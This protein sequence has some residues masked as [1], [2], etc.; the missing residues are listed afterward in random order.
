MGH[1][2]CRPFRLPVPDYPTLLRFYLPLIEPD[3]RISRIRLSDKVF[4][5]S[6]TREFA[7][8]AQALPNARPGTGI[9]RRIVLSPDPVPCA[10]HT[11]TDAADDA[12]LVLELS[13][14]VRGWIQSAIHGLLARRRTIFF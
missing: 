9:C 14:E 13:E 4:K 10:S 11:T 2:C 3:G 12:R 7:C 1:A 8:A 5:P 6:P